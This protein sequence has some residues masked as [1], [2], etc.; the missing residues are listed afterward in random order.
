MSDPLT[1]ELGPKPQRGRMKR[2]D[3]R[4]LILA[5]AL[6]TIGEEGYRAF[7]LPKL[8]R[9]CGLTNAGL[10]HHVGSKEGLL[11][12]LLEER[13]RLDEIAVV[14]MALGGAPAAPSTREG[15]LHLLRTVVI[16]NSQQPELVRLYVMLRTEALMRDHP[17]HAYFAERE[18]ASIEAFRQLVAPY[19]TDAL[20]VGRQIS[21]LMIG[22]EAQWLRENADFDLVGEWDKV[23]DKIIA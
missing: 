6:R 5:E 21:A 11:I 18:A 13:D 12:A 10:L 9:R 17:A 14:A 1:V 8:A 3:R 22:L 19:A 15:V 20:A 4:Q 7:S 16:R 2:P 23:A